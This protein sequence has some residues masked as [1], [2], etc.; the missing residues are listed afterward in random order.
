MCFLINHVLSWTLFA[1]EIWLLE[2]TLFDLIVIPFFHIPRRFKCNC[3][4]LLFQS[5]N[6]VIIYLL[7]ACC[8]ES[9]YYL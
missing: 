8:S 9:F 7:I 3:D 4:D 5:I 6:D 2:A 1:K